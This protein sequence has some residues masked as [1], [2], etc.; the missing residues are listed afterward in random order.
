MVTR[1]SVK[2]TR[3]AV[4]NAVCSHN[5]EHTVAETGSVAASMDDFTGPTS[6]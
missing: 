3:S 5:A 6:A 2:P 1:I 4:E